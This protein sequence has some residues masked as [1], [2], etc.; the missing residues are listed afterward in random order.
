MTNEEVQRLAREHADRNEALPDHVLERLTPEQ[1]KLAADVYKAEGERAHADAE[2]L[3]NL[4]D[5]V[6]KQH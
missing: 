5:A 6:T 3:G 2:A 1:I 4:H